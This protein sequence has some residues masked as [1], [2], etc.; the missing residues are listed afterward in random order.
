MATTSQRSGRIS[1]FITAA[2]PEAGGNSTAAWQGTRPATNS[3]DRS[4]PAGLTQDN[5]ETNDHMLQGS[6]ILLLS[7][8]YL[9]LLFAVA[10]LGDRLA[11]R[12]YK[13]RSGA[14]IYALSLAIYCTSWTFYGRSEEHTSELQSLM[15]TSYA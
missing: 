12:W 1:A 5:R 14:T 13:G 11:D 7:L 4:R 8:G 3:V 9:G 10:H 15:R 6:A 2:E